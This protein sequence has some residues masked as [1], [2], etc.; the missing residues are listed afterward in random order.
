MVRTLFDRHSPVWR[1]VGAAAFA[2]MVSSAA[3]AADP[4]TV[5]TRA[6]PATPAERA[7]PAT[8]AETP[9]QAYQRQRAACLAGQTPQDRQTCLKEAGAALAAARR[10]QLTEATPRASVALERC[11]VHRDADDRLACERMAL[12]EGKVEGSVAEGAV[13]KEMV[14]RSVEPPAR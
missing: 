13:V 6:A 3:V 14:T 2:A 12:G 8:P 7:T 9:A 10:G 4:A 1:A 5:A 11:A